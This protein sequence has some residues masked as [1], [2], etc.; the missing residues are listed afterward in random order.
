MPNRAPNI[1]GREEKEKNINYTNHDIRHGLSISVL[2]RVSTSSSVTPFLE[3]LGRS[4]LAL[5]RQVMV[6]AFGAI[7]GSNTAS[8]RH[9]FFGDLLRTNLVGCSLAVSVID[10]SYLVT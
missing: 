4:N 3:L 1:R 6:R 5:V 10:D 2:P 7:S 8:S 9:F